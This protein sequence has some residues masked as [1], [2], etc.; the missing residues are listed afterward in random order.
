[1]NKYTAWR[2]VSNARRVFKY[3]HVV[4]AAGYMPPYT[5]QRVLVGCCVC[6]VLLGLYYLVSFPVVAVRR[7]GHVHVQFPF[8]AL[9]RK[10]VLSRNGGDYDSL[11]PMPLKESFSYHGEDKFAWRE[12]F[13]GCRGGTFVELGALDGIRQSNTLAMEREAEWKGVL[14]E[15]SPSSFARLQI[16]RPD[17]ILVR[18]AM[19]DIAGSVE[20]VTLGDPA[21]HAM[22]VHFDNDTTYRIYKQLPRFGAWEESVWCIPIQYVF[23]L[24]GITH[25]DFFSLD[26]EGSEPKVLGGID[27]ARMTFDVLV[28]E[29]DKLGAF[30]LVTYMYDRGYDR[31]PN[32]NDRWNTWFVRRGARPCNK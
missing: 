31:Y 11:S 10:Y 23:D 22:K 30:P 17:Q 19:C 3:F 18:A 21:M 13:L 9:D 25:V 12:F 14:I 26:V 6:G 1:M 20:F 16:N 27:W 5:G 28:I 8:W 4:D 2:C 32:V 7:H 29:S 15:A 24:V